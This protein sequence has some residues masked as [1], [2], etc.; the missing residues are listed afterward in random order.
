[1]KMTAFWDIVLYSLAEQTDISEVHTAFII[2]V[3]KIS[4]TGK[5]DYREVD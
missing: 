4:C 2:R 3:M 5:F 1:M